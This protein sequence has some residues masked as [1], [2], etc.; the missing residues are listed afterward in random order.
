VIGALPDVWRSRSR[1]RKG[2]T[3]ARA[4]DLIDSMPI[5]TANLL[6]RELGVSFQA[7][8]TALHALADSGI[9]RERTGQSRYR[10]FAAEEVIAV[11]ARPFGEDP[12]IA[13]E[14]ARVS[15]GVE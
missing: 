8:S 10:V 3:A 9:V 5:V 6:S 7:A 14:G 13:L 1:F 12:E 15:L 2:S 11:L 4:L